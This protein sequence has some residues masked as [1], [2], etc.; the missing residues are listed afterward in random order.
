VCA[1]AVPDLAHGPPPVATILAGAPPPA[2]TAK[3]TRR[4]TGKGARCPACG[5][6]IADYADHQQLGCAACYTAFARQ[7]AGPIRSWHGT[8]RHVARSADAGAAAQRADLDRR[9]RDAVAAE[10]FEEAARLRDHLR[11]LGN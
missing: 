6:A 4:R 7:L 10:R 5:F 1:A 8:N 11:T 3:P 2:P 9:L